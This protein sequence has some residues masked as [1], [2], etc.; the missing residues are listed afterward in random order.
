MQRRMSSYSAI[1]GC[2]NSN[3]PSVIKSLQTVFSLSHVFPGIPSR[4]SIIAPFQMAVLGVSVINLLHV[5]YL[6]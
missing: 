2:N 6:L 1:S 3:V 4:I 5:S